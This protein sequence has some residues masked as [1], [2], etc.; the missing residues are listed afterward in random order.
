MVSSSALNAADLSSMRGVGPETGGRFDTLD[1]AQYAPLDFLRK[2]ELSNGRS[3][4]LATA[5]WSFPTLWTFP[6]GLYRAETDGKS[7]KGEI[8][9]EAAIEWT[10]NWAKL[11]D[12]QNED[13]EIKELKN[14]R[15]AIFGM[16]GYFASV[17]VSGSVPALS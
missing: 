13:M 1:L 8:G 10:G 7:Y 5:G 14:G 6:D 12:A 17:L 11:D 9:K 2:A 3:A 15:L 16:A 4:M